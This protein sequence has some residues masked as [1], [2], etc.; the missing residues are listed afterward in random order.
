M[1]SVKRAIKKQFPRFNLRSRAETE[2]EIYFV[3][4]STAPKVSKTIQCD[5]SDEENCDL[6]K[7]LPFLLSY[8]DLLKPINEADCSE[9]QT[10]EPEQRLPTAFTSPE[11]ANV[12]QREPID[13]GIEQNSDS[14]IQSSVAGVE[15]SRKQPI[16]PE[17]G[18]EEFQP[19]QSSSSTCPPHYS[20]ALAASK[21]RRQRRYRRRKRRIRILYEDTQSFTNSSN[22]F[23]A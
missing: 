20:P 23:A 17:V 16:S 22:Q 2:P 15:N 18:L 19:S 11:Q 1:K 6:S 14:L 12:T 8:G 13:I 10:E 3:P 4:L 9:S 21:S 5:L 7:E